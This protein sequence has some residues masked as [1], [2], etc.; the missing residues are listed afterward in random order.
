M[1]DEY[2]RFYVG[3]KVFNAVAGK[4][5]FRDNLVRQFPGEVAAIDHNR[6]FLHDRTI[7]TTHW[8]QQYC[9]IEDLDAL[10]A[11]VRR[12]V[13]IPIEAYGPEFGTLLG[14]D[15]MEIGRAHV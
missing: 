6:A 10:E 12:F 11:Q 9:R 1:A 5:A 13:E 2:D 14:P 15:R 4:Q 3:D 8:R 7:T